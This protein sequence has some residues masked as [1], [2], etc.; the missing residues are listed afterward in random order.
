MAGLPSCDRLQNACHSTDKQRGE[1]LE[2]EENLEKKAATGASGDRRAAMV[3]KLRQRRHVAAGL[4]MIRAKFTRDSSSFAGCDRPLRLGEAASEPLLLLRNG[5]RR[6][7][8]SRAISARR[9]TGGARTRKENAPRAELRRERSRKRVDRFAPADVAPH[10]TSCIAI[11]D[12]SY[13]SE[14]HET[15]AQ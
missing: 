15:D 13:N 7:S 3:T 2:T 11:S 5:A 9:E 6:C 10:H 8:R 4:R 12:T 14:R 1:D